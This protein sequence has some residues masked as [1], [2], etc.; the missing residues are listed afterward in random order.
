MR[1]AAIRKVEWGLGLLNPSNVNSETIGKILKAVV[2]LK[3]HFAT[4]ISDHMG[5]KFGESWI[6]VA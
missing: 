3:R 4:V 6:C 2:R 5:E 1:D